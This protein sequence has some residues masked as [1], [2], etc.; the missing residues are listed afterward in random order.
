M[1]SPQQRHLGQLS[2]KRQC[3]HQSTNSINVLR[4]KIEKNLCNQADKKLW[5]MTLP[6]KIYIYILFFFY[7]QYFFSFY[8]IHMLEQI[9]QAIDIKVCHCEQGRARGGQPHPFYKTKIY[10][11]IL[12]SLKVIKWC[13]IATPKINVPNFICY[14]LEFIYNAIYSF[15][16]VGNRHNLRQEK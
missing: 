8:Y 7:D 10:I 6:R 3:Q 1:Q 4:F 14:F 11:Y 16:F 9:I 12:H 15:K 5:K 13:T 2:V